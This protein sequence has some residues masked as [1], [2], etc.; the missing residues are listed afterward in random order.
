[1]LGGFVLAAGFLL[2]SYSSVL[3]QYFW[4]EDDFAYV[5]NAINENSPAYILNSEF[6]VR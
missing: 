5:S 4:D 2:L 6:Y 3:S 1:M